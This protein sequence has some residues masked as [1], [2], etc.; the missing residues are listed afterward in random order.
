MSGIIEFINSYFFL[1]IFL[2]WLTSVFIKGIIKAARREKNYFRS[3]FSNGGMPSSH[4]ALVCSLSAAIYLQEGLTPAF[5]VSLILAIIIMSD[6]IKVRKNLGE[7][8]DSLNKLLVKFKQHPIRVVHGHSTI[9]VLAG[10]LWGLIVS[11]VI[12]HLI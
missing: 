7:Q 4:S 10:A 6:A 11:V 5:F 1:A 12:M 8:G 9:Q 2:A 3:A